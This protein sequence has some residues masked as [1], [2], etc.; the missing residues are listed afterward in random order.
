MHY[1]SIKRVAQHSHEVTLYDVVDTGQTLIYKV[2]AMR[3]SLAQLDNNQQV[4]STAQTAMQQQHENLQ[5]RQ[6][7]SQ[8]L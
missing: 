4:A 8:M 7:Q 3:S 1:G 6:A 2:Q 5:T